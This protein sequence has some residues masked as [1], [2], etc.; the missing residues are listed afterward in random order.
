MAFDIG[1]VVQLKSGSPAMTITSF[2]TD[3]QGKRSMTC[4]WFDNGTEKSGT[5]PPEAL[6]VYASEPDDE[7][8]RD[9]MTS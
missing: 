3:A 1:A 6:T 7:G 8:G 4:T 2:H 5:F 9:Y